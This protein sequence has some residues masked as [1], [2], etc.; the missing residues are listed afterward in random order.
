MKK[1]AESLV[2]IMSFMAPEDIASGSKRP[3]INVPVLTA[4]P[5]LTTTDPPE[6]AVSFLLLQKEV[7]PTALIDQC[8]LKRSQNLRVDT[9]Q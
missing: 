5:V 9:S 4:N 7:Y 8:I 1:V 3:R 2:H 6:V